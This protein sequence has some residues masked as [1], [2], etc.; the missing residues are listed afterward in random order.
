MPEP[1]YQFGA[2]EPQPRPTADQPARQRIKAQAPPATA[3][4]TQQARA[5]RGPKEHR[6]ATTVSAA[7]TRSPQER[8]EFPHLSPLKRAVILREVLDRR[9]G[10]HR[11]LG[12]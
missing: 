11:F 1:E 9:R 10:P 5:A 3:R 2:T 8:L 7:E 6:P 4:Q 12:T